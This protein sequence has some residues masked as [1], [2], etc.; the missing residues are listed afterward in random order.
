MWGHLQTFTVNVLRGN[1]TL[2]LHSKKSGP[3]GKGAKTNRG[4]HKEGLQA[5][6]PY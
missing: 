4:I 6:D 3:K 5:V 2:N 1:L